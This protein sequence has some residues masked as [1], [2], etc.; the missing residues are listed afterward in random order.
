[1][2]AFKVQ[3][4]LYALLKA[5]VFEGVRFE[6]RALLKTRAFE[7]VRFL[8]VSVFKRYVLLQKMSVKNLA[9]ML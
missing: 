5:C 8:K 4:F 1:M 9:A 6:R 7:G 2:E 3:S